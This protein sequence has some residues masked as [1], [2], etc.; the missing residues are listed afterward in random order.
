LFV[1]FCGGGGV[2]GVM[3]FAGCH[4]RV[5]EIIIVVC[6]GQT[7]VG[8]GVVFGNGG[9]R[10]QLLLSIDRRGRRWRTM[11]GRGL[12]INVQLLEASRSV[13]ALEENVLVVRRPFV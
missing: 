5:V 2:V 10:G 12:H 11:D 7:T 3:S 9:Y 8:G 4:T 6:I 1:W 13:G